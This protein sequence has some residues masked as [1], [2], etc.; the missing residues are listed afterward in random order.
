M[1]ED[2]DG[3]KTPKRHFDEGQYVDM[4]KDKL[5]DEREGR[6]ISGYLGF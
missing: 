3:K 5:T 6:R 4:V 2:D 1:K